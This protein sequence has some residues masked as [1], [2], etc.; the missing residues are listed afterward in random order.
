MFEYINVSEL[1]YKR[2]INR[3]ER[4]LQPL[5]PINIDKVKG[6]GSIPYNNNYLSWGNIT[7]SIDSNTTIIK[8]VILDKNISEIIVKKANQ[9]TTDIS[10]KYTYGLISTFSDFN[11]NKYIRRTFSNDKM[12]FFD[13][14]QNPYFYFEDFNSNDL[15]HKVKEASKYEFNVCTLDLETFV[16][17][18]NEHQILCACFYDGNETFKFYISDY[19]CPEEL[20]MDLF[21]T[22]MQPKYHKTNIYIHNGSSFD[23]VFLLKPL[24]ELTSDNSIKIDPVIKDGK[25]FKY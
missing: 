5:L 22:I 10:I 20:L 7:E 17:S 4:A 6:Y 25:F 2:D 11:K 14:S 9:F 18:N 8:D 21:E 24:Y 13:D 3:R 12:V 1:D 16:D 19:S 23:L 15:M